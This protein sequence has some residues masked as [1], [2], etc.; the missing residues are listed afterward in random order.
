MVK[1]ALSPRVAEPG[2]SAAFLTG[3]PEVGLAL[4]PL[5]PR[6]AAGAVDVR[7]GFLREDV[8]SGDLG[9]SFFCGLPKVELQKELPPPHVE[10]NESDDCCV[11]ALGVVGASGLGS[12]W[13]CLGWNQDENEE[14]ELGP[15]SEEPLLS[16]SVAV[17]LG[18]LEAATVETL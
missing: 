17:L 3:P 12:G 2:V 10:E 6:D 9:C 1:S 5:L 16:A 11:G 7:E 18:L 13:A 4:L 15:T 14:A 8:A